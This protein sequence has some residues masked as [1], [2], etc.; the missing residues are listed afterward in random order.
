MGEA[1]S[2]VGNLKSNNFNKLHDFLV[3][4]P[5]SNIER[6]STIKKKE[7]PGLVKKAISSDLS[8]DFLWHTASGACRA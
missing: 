2:R 3:K 5:T 1:F 8:P 4:D 6:E 7:N